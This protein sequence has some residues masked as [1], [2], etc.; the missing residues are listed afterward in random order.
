MGKSQ[1]LMNLNSV[2]VPRCELY[3]EISPIPLI[4]NKKNKFHTNY[5]YS[6]NEY[7]NRVIYLSE[8]MFV[9]LYK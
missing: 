5:K 9:C 6:G 8:A 4:L 1:M 3:N 2:M 7:L